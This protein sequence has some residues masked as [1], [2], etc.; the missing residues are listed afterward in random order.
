MTMLKSALISFTLASGMLL[1]VSG[2]SSVMT[3]TGD[4]QGY[5]SGTRAGV[6]MLRADDTSWAMAPLVVIDLPFSAMLDTLLLPYDYYHSDDQ[7]STRQRIQRSE[8]RNDVLTSPP[9]R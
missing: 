4:S 6:D 8:Q 2:C 7:D 9:E 1:S 3:H 5:Y